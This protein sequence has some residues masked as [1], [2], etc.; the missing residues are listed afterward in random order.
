ML[1]EIAKMS[2]MEPAQRDRL[3]HLQEGFMG[4][5]PMDAAWI[6]ETVETL[7]KHSKMVKDMLRGRGAMIG[8]F[9]DEQMEGFLD[10]VGS[11]AP[12][13][14]RWIIVAI[15][16]LSS[17]YKPAVE[18]YKYLDRVTLGLAQYIIGALMLFV[19]YLWGCAA[20]YVLRWLYRLVFVAKAATV[21]GAASG[22]GTA[23]STAS[24]ANS[25]AESLSGAVTN[26]GAST[27]DLGGNI[28]GA[29]DDF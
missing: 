10:G 25:L 13:T 23:A 21:A 6:D 19:L 29:A 7:T 15:I 9:T 4:Q 1:A 11:L 12:G 2:R 5:R 24:V 3:Q 17:F 27:V 22:A 28:G 18:W 26:A 8:N 14:L 20:W 16:Y